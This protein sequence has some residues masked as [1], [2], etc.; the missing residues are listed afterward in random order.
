MPYE[1]KQAKYYTQADNRHINLIVIHD[2]EAS[3][4]KH[5]AEAV[6]EMFSSANSPEAS[7]HISFDENSGY[8]SVH[9]GDIAWGAPNANTHGYQIEHAGHAKDSRGEWLDNSNRHMLERSAEHSAEVALR[10][11]I[12]VNHML[13]DDHILAAMNGDHLHSGFVGHIDVSRVSAANDLPGDHS[14]TDPGEHFPWGY[15]IDLVK[16][17]QKKINK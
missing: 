6:A 1:F 4:G 8:R 9:E 7:A 17:Y 15:Y 3:Q 12:N 16:H 5:T 13:Y 14:H 11:K 2:M 10:N